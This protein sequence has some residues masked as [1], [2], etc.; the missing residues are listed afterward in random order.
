MPDAPNT[1]APEEREQVAPDYE[2]PRAE[3]VA[4][5]DRAITAPGAAS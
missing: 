1:P 2:P 3:D 5:D 4:A